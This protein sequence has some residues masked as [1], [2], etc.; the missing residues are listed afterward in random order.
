MAIDKDIKRVT[1]DTYPIKIQDLKIDGATVDLSTSTGDLKYNK[2]GQ[3]I[4]IIGSEGDAQGNML[5]KPSAL[6]FDTLGKFKYDIT[7]NDGEYIT[8]YFSGVISVE[9]S[10]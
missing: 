7:I 10:I 9:E 4:T 5:F 2:N 8:T 3:I 1:G 6:D